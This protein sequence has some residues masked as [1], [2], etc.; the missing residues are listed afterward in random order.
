MYERESTLFRELEVKYSRYFV[1]ETPIEY[2]K[3]LDIFRKESGVNF[4]FF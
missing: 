4:S 3:K 2:N 1:Y